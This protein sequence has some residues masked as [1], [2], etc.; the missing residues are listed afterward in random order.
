[1][2]KVNISVIL[3]DCSFR[4]NFHAI[5]SYLDQNLP[6]GS[7]EVI[8]VEFY[9][10]VSPQVLSFQ[11]K[12]SNFRI[13][14]LGLKGQWHYG[15][16]INEGV[17]ISRG[18]IVI[19]SDGD[20]VVDNN[21][22]EDELEIQRNEKELVNYHRRYDELVQPEKYNVKIEY[23]KEI[24]TFKHVDNFAGCFSMWKKDFIAV[25]GYEEDM[26]FSGPSACAR[27]A[28]IRFKNNGFKVRW[29]V[30]KRL[31]HPWHRGTAPTISY[32]LS[33]QDRM[34]KKR[35]LNL[36][37]YPNYGYNSKLNRTEEAIDIIEEL[38]L[39]SKIKEILRTIILRIMN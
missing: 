14:K 10:K 37:I 13:H 19:I 18:D 1:M 5:E 7:F 39:K 29:D 28:Y 17:R 25:N 9:D 38:G 15:K 30:K 11:E 36:N 32:L 31:F 27:D 16:C 26:V 21:F 12:Y 8:W 4:E 3:W 34:I 33:N 22:I 35:A 23:L 2:S 24:T 6:S 20:V